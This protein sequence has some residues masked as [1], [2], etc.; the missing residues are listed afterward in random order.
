[1]LDPLT[2]ATRPLPVR[3][4]AE[5]RQYDPEI[6]GEAAAFLVRIG[7]PEAEGRVWLDR[8]G[9]TLKEEAFGFTLT[10][11]DNQEEARRDITPLSPPPALLGLLERGALADLRSRLSF[12][13]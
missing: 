8:F 12:K 10:L 6:A 4:E 7:P 5:V 9:R 2:R 1:M 13:P 11:V 3:V